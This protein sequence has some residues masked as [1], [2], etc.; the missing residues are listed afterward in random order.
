VGEREREIGF[1]AV[2]YLQRDIPEV[3]DIFAHHSSL[4]ILQYKLQTLVRSYEA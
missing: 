3:I 1:D 2:V 4:Q